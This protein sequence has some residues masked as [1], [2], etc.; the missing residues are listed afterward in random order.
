MGVKNYIYAI[1]DTV[2]GTLY[3]ETSTIYPTGDFVLLGEIT[4][5]TIKQNFDRFAR[6]KSGSVG[7]NIAH[8][9]TINPFSYS[10]ST[11]IYE[12][13]FDLTKYNFVQVEFMN[14][15][16]ETGKTEVTAFASFDITN[17]HNISYCYRVFGSNTNYYTDFDKTRAGSMIGDSMA[18][19]KDLGKIKIVGQGTLY[20]SGYFR[21]TFS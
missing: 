16:K 8:T 7:A 12:S 13:D 5:L 20:A 4:D 2:K 17:N 15:V 1:N 11:T 3:C 9:V 10:T 21:I 18:L 6:F 19:S 14:M